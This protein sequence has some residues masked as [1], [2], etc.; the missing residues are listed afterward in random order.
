[1]SKLKKWREDRKLS[2]EQAGRLFEVSAVAFGRY[3]RGRVP[4]P[5]VLQ[6][7]IDGTAG[8]ITANDFFDLPEEPTR[9][10]A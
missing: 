8:E 7:I 10:A 9:S 5:E 6:K 2:Q 3:E 1:M 4:E